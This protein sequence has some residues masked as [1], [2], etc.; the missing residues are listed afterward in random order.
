VKVELDLPEPELRRIQAYAAVMRRRPSEVIR[1]AC[2]EYVDRH[3]GD[4]DYQAA[5]QAGRTSPEGPSQ[6]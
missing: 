2:T 4:P 6:P 5:L 3:T 1:A